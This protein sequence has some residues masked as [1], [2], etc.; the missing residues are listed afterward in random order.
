[1]NQLKSGFK[2]SEFWISFVMLLGSL[3]V[4]FANAMG[5]QDLATT[6]LSGLTGL[7]GLLGYAVPRVQLKRT[8]LKV[9]A[10]MEPE[11]VDAGNDEEDA[12]GEENP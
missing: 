8:H 5:K 12:D 7:G 3:A 11:T 1:M 9:N 2:T 6:I 10:L 4:L